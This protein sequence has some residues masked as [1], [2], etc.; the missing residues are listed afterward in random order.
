MIFEDSP[1]VALFRVIEASMDERPEEWTADHYRISNLAMGT[2]VWISNATYGIHVEVSGARIDANWR[3]RKRLRRAVNKCIAA[4][5]VSAL[6][7]RL[8]QYRER[9]AGANV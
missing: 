4:Q 6:K 3:W 1:Q 9:K 7:V 5:A 2:S 8:G